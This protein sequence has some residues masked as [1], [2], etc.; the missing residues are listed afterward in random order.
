MHRRRD[1]NAAENQ[2]NA[3]GEILLAEFRLHHADQA[4][5]CHPEPVVRARDLLFTAQDAT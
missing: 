4:P 2:F 3:H 1:S 5:Q